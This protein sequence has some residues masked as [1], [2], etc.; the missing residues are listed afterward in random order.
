MWPGTP[1]VQWDGRQYARTPPKVTGDK[2]DYNLHG[3]V[4]EPGIH[5]HINY[6]D[7]QVWLYQ[8]KLKAMEVLRA[9]L[10]DRMIAE[11]E[12]ARSR[13]RRTMVGTGDRSAKIRTYNYPQSRVTDHRIGFS[14]HNLPEVMNG[15]LD[16]IV[17]ALR[18]ASREEAAVA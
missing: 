17:D 18:L 11:Q 9:R 6:L 3:T 2:G 12:A 14:V 1:I 10:L 8:N 15:G 13:E 7:Y 5:N 16:E 4:T